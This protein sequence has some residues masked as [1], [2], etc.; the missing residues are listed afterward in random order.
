MPPDKKSPYRLVVEGKDDKHAVVQLLKQHGY[1]WDDASR[2]RPY[3]YEAGGAEAVID[4]IGPGLLSHT[5]YGIVIDADDNPQVR[6][7]SIRGQI[8]RRGFPAPQ[9]PP[10]D[11]LVLDAPGDLPKRVGVW[12]MPDNSTPGMLEDFLTR[13]VPACDPCWTHANQ[14]TDEARSKGAP[15]RQRDHSKGV[16]HTWL[17]WREIPGQPFGTALTAHVFSHDMPEALQ[18]VDWFRRMFGD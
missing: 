10:R 11:G 18:F 7:Q 12:L 5:R 2:V 8:G 14:S 13:L 1:D 4:S 6:W 3:V 17:A 16:L 15:L 9:I